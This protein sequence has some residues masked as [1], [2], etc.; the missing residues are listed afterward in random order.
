M[1]RIAIGW[2]RPHPAVPVKAR[3]IDIT[4][5]ICNQYSRDSSH[6]NSDE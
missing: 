3:D 6:D 5:L 2:G 4:R 1:D